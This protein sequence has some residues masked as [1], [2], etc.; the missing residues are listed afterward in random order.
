LVARTYLCRAWIDAVL[1]DAARAFT[2]ALF[3]A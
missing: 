2:G 3:A 1:D